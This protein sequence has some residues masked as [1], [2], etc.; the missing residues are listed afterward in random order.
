MGERLHGMQEVSWVRA[1]PTPPMS[2]FHEPIDPEILREA[3]AEVDVPGFASAF[4]AQWIRV[5]R[6]EQHGHAYSERCELCDAADVL[7]T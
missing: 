4:R 5:Q 6:A 1:P 2:S 7:E 3:L